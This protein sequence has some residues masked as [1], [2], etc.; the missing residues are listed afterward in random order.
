VQFAQ[1]AVDNDDLAN[2]LGYVEVAL[3]NVR[4]GDPLGGPLAAIGK[5]SG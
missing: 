1:W 2:Y 5:E 3:F 4:T